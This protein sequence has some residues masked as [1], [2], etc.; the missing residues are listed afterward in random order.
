M[1]IRDSTHLASIEQTV[2]GLLLVCG[3]EGW[4]ET[5]LASTLRWWRQVL[6]ARA[7]LVWGFVRAPSDLIVVAWRGPWILWRGTKRVL[8]LL[9]VI[10][11]VIVC[12]LKEQ[13]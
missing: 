13:R 7:W 6:H 4:G 3:R 11:G 12:W 1:C 10:F 9:A 5:R 8:W 2:Y